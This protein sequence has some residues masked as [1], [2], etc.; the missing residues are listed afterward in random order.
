MKKY[1]KLILVS[2]LVVGCSDFLN[3][4]N[5]NN[6]PVQ[7]TETAKKNNLFDSNF[8]EPTAGPFSEKNLLLN[9]GLNVIAPATD[10]FANEMQIFHL[11]LEKLC[12][13][14][15]LSFADFKQEILPDWKNVVYSFHK[16]DSVSFGPLTLKNSNSNLDPRTEIYSWPYSNFCLADKSVY[17]IHFKTTTQQGL[18]FNSKSLDTV[19]YLLF[20]NLDQVKCNLRAQPQLQAWLDLSEKIRLDSRCEL[21]AQMTSKLVEKSI[22]LKNSWN[23]TEGNYSKTLVDGSKYSSFKIALNDFTDVIYTIETIKDQR[24]G[25]PLGRN[26]NECPTASC[27]DRIEHKF[28]ELGF[29]ALAARL[30]GFKEGFFGGSENAPNQYGIDDYL[31]QSGHNEITIKIHTELSAA[32]SLLEKIMKGGSLNEQ[33]LKIDHDLCQTST[34]DNAAEPICGLYKN[35]QLLTTTLRTEVL[36]A[37]SLKSP[38]IYQGDND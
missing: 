7:A 30:D 14:T 31:N 20:S 9:I 15:S 1:L 34:A 17:D 6:D 11:R 19:E 33:I 25:I 23:R 4:E 18:P 2:F 16:M 36:V 26:K 8:Q 22:E 21:A 27:P 13:K 10:S 32:Q 38:P 35:I 3:T 28:S 24:L 5:V 29:V 12:K 37:L